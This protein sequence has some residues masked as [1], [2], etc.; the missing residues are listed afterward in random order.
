MEVEPVEPVPQQVDAPPNVEKPP[1]PKP[2]PPELGE[3][4][5]PMA[6]VQK[7]MKADKELP[8]VTKE[9]VHTISVATEEFIKRL[10]AAAYQ[11]ASRERR[12][13]VQYKDVA[14]AVKRN[15]EMHFLEEMI[16]T[17]TPAPVALAQHKQKLAE[18]NS[19]VKV[20]T[21]AATPAN[22]RKTAGPKGASSNGK[23]KA[24]AAASASAGPSAAASTEGTPDVPDE[25]TEMDLS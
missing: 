25:R 17:A 18:R 16:P 7:I 2:A 19:A 11:Q 13:M 4:I 8:N 10:S 3:S 23:N 21:P 22:G 9:A 20:T 15:P 24:L 12:T 1:K 14:L 5:L 6:R